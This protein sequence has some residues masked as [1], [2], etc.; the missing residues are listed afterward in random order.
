MGTHAQIEKQIK[1]RSI[2]EVW[3]GEEYVY[4][5][6]TTTESSRG[7]KNIPITIRLDNGALIL[8]YGQIHW[9]SE[10]AKVFN[11]LTK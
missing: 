4:D 8:V 6:P 10:K 2:Q 3:L 9:V 1:G 11:L 7:G 5:G